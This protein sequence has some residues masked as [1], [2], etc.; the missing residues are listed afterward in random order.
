[1]RRVLLLFSVLILSCSEA[2]VDTS[3]ISILKI[4]NS[5]KQCFSGKNELIISDEKT[6]KK[7]YNL[8]SKNRRK[9]N[10][11][12]KSNYGYLSVETIKP[13][14]LFFDVVFTT[15]TGNVI[16]ADGVFYKNE[17]LV[18]YIK[19]LI[20]IDKRIKENKGCYDRKA[21]Y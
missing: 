5:A 8:F 13:K 19:S 21:L 11:F 16:Y 4:R 6:L 7:I 12:V 17:E 10:A 14:K 9:R 18:S 15:D 1:M 3:K 2:K 20:G